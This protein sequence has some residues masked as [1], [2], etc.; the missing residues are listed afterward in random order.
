MDRNNNFHHKESGFQLFQNPFK[1][2]S[3]PR[4]LLWAS[5]FPMS[6]VVPVVGIVSAQLQMATYRGI[7][8]NTS[9][10]IGTVARLVAVD[11]LNSIHSKF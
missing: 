9:Y 4:M 7:C 10:R 8:S 11:S 2:C 1:V 5:P 3:R 6:L